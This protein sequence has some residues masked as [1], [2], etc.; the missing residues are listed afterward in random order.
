[1]IWTYTGKNFTNQLSRALNQAGFRTFE[2]GDDNNESRRE[3]EINSEL[4]KAI[5]DSKMCIIVFSQNYASPSW[6]LDQLVSILEYKM[7]FA[8]MILPIFYHVDPSNLRKHKGS[9]GEALNRH[10]EKFKCERVDEKEYWED[11]LKK[12]KDALSQAADLAGMV[13]ENQ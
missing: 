7:K 10:E 3:A 11:K 4:F 1:M 8:C 2:G 9:F 6:C 13:L 12:W 5:Q